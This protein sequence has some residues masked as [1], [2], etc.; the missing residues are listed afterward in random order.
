MAL[1]FRLPPCRPEPLKRKT[2][3]KFG[4]TNCTMAAISS[5][6]QLKL[7]G[8]LKSGVFLVLSFVAGW[9]IVL[10]SGYVTLDGFGIVNNRTQAKSNRQVLWNN[11]FSREKQVIARHSP[12]SPVYWFR[13]VSRTTD[14][15]PFVSRKC[16]LIDISTVVDCGVDPTH[17][18]NRS[19]PTMK[20][21]IT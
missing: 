14:K 12:E 7:H 20:H 6:A 4:L 15:R 1:A 9:Y 3:G 17:K 16:T 10:R 19:V 21:N 5:R 18:P 11:F 8:A 13:L 2:R